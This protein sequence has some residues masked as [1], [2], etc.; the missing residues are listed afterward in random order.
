THVHSGHGGVIDLIRLLPFQTM[1]LVS[2]VMEKCI[3]LLLQPIFVWDMAKPHSELSPRPHQWFWRKGIHMVHVSGGD[4]HVVALGFNGIC[5]L[6]ALLYRRMDSEE[7]CGKER[8]VSTQ[9]A[10]GFLVV[11]R[12]GVS[13]GCERAAVWSYGIT[14]LQLAHGHASFSKYP[15]LLLA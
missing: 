15:R 2:Q 13:Q 7:F 10:T 8:M 6:S 14:T 1:H 9:L 11:E 3:H 5:K 4:E 12:D